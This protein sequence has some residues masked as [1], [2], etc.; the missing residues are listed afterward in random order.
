MGSEM[1]EEAIF[2]TP[3]NTP[4]DT[5]TNASESESESVSAVPVPESESV[6]TLVSNPNTNT[7]TNTNP[8]GH[9]HVLSTTRY[10]FVTLP[11]TPMW[12]PQTHH[13]FPTHFQATIR[14]IVYS[15]H[16]ARV[17]LP[18]HVWMHVFTFLER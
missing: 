9:I 18:L 12:S 2:H 10:D 17:S 8:N 4:T 7:N 6:S 13:T 1:D 16:R 3:T 15:R 5:P 14:S 11:P